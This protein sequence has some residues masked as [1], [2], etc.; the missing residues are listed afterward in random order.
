MKKQNKELGGKLAALKGKH[1]KLL[2]Q[3]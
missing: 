3:S 2:E 1:Q